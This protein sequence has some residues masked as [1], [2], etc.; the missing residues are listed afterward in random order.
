MI[1]NKIMVHEGKNLNGTHPFNPTYKSNLQTELILCSKVLFEKQTVTQPIKQLP[2][3]EGT[4]KLLTLFKQ[5]LE[6][7]TSV[8]GGGI[9]GGGFNPLRNSKALQNRAKLNLIV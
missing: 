5:T 1:S 4:L 6:W 9:P 2:A 3:I 8:S 7:D